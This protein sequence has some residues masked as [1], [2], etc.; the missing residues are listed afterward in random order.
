MRTW[1]LELL[2]VGVVLGLMLV[3]TSAPPVELVGAGAVLAGFAHAQIS[4][5]MA[6]AQAALPAPSVHCY[7]WALRYFVAKE[8]LWVG[9]FVLHH[10]YAALVGCWVFLAYPVWRRAW[11]ARR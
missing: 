2:A 1:Q 4:D 9:Y 5:R 10:S 6:A 7:R 11:R 3:V 8:A